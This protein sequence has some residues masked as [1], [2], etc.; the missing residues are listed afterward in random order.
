MITTMPENVLFIPYEK[1]MPLKL[2]LKH[3]VSCELIL[4]RE[5]VELLNK[6][7]P[8]GSISC[9]LSD[10]NKFETFDLH[11]LMEKLLI[12]KVRGAKNYFYKLTEFGKRVVDF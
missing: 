5:A 2:E 7:K 6:T 1:R 3:N 11:L 12:E 10:V 9:L 4:T 8:T